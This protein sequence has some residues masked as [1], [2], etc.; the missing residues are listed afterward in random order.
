MLGTHEALSHGGSCDPGLA[1]TR[2]EEFREGRHLIEGRVRQ[3]DRKILERGPAVRVFLMKEMAFQ[4]SD[5]ALGDEA[6]EPKSESDTA[7]EQER[8]SS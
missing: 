5:E 6:H 1:L 2:L 4:V 7:E 3:A 8:A